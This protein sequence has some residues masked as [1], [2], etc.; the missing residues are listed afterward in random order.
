MCIRDSSRIALILIAMMLAYAGA[1]YFVGMYI[2]TPLFLIASMSFL[3]MKQWKVLIP[4]SIG[5]DLFIFL[6]F[7]LVFKVTIPMGVFFGG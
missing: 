6:V 3:G 5:M 4:V 2:T 1:T 7:H